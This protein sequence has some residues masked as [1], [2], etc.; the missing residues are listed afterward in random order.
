M[1]HALVVGIGNPLRGDD[2]AGHHVVHAL[3]ARRPDLRCL[4]VHQLG[5]ELAPEAAESEWVVFVDASVRV[6]EVTVAALEHGGA[7]A[8]G[9]HHGRPEDVLA[10]AAALYGSAPEA[11]LVEVPAF[12]LE[13]GER[14]SREA[15]L[16][17][18][19]AV[20]R[21]EAILD[22]AETRT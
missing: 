2:A 3:E 4:A 19:E 14:L 1:K 18:R 10:A 20:I 15:A 12:D 16:G 21:I 6:R 11:W 8:G 22:A 13:H 9:S 17:V 7:I 5:I